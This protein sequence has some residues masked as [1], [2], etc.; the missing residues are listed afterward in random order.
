MMILLN[1]DFYCDNHPEHINTRTLCGRVQFSM[2]HLALHT[3]SYHQAGKE[4]NGSKATNCLVTPVLL[5]EWNV[6]GWW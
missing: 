4:I 3:Y 6:Q 1:N 2:L 5:P